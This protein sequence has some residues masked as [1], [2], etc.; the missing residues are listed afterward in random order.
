M[1]K[2]NKKIN[3]LTCDK[4]TQSLSCFYRLPHADQTRDNIQTWRNQGAKECGVPFHSLL[5]TA[6]ATENES[7][8]S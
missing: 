4:C 1:N 5:D 7:M 8:R 2:K 6:A 3:T